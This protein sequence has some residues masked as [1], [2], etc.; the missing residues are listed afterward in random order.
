MPDYCHNCMNPLEAGARNCPNCGRSPSAKNEAHQLRAGA[1]LQNRYLV[2]RVL[3]QGGF[4]ITYIGRDTLLNMRVAIKEFYPN[5]CAGRDHARSD[6]VS[7]MQDDA[8]L[9]RKGKA[10]FL[11][12]AQTIASLGRTPGIVG[13]H[14]YFEANGTAYIV[15]EYLD[16][17]TL[18][19]FIAARGKV[20][21]QALLR[22]MRPLIS[23]LENIHAQGIL[24]RDISPESIMLLRDGTLRLLD[25]GA[26]CEMDSEKSISV[27]LKPGYAP[28]EQ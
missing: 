19:R 20:G 3:G 2:G 22:V 4:G 21:A 18:G 14:D 24:H 28:E 5:G 8:E 9:F 12:E 25:F 1:L 11:R 27:V 16:G 26:A 15:M 23:A 13:I 7:L 17:I 10:K 6:A